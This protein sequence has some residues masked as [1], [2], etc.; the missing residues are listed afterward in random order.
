MSIIFNRDLPPKNDKIGTTELVHE[1]VSEPEHH[2]DKSNKPSFVDQMKNSSQPKVTS[3][4]NG[5][6]DTA[7]KASTRPVRSTRS[8]VTYETAEPLEDSKVERFSIEV[9]LGK[10]W[11]K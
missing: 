6:R 9:G 11:N 10:P 3:S 8:A 2:N 4:S 7:V 1:P 5:G